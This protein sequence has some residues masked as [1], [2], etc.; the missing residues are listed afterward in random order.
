M[1]DLLPA[2]LGVA[3]VAAAAA[4]TLLP[5]IRGARVATDTPHTSLST[6]RALLY[7]QVLELEFDHQVGKLSDEDF[8]ELSAD[9]LAHA[10]DLLREER[11]SLGELDDEIER[12]IAA[13]RAA[14]AAARR[15]RSPRKRKRTVETVP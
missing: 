11:G 2:L 1:T 13:A 9:L 15:P 14:F 8:R 5:F 10:S 4:Y 12:E 6:E 3:L 7:R